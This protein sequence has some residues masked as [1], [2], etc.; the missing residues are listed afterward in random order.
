MSEDAGRKAAMPEPP[1]RVGGGTAEG[2][3]LVR[4]TDTARIEQAGDGAMMLMEQAVRRL[5]SLLD[6]SRRLACGA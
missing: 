4:E 2:M 3:G 5:S 1:R 6:E